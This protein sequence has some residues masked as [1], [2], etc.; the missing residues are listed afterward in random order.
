MNEAISTLTVM[1]KTSTEI[2]LYVSKVK[3]GLLE[4]YVTGLDAAQ[5]LKSME[6][7]VK[8]LKS[9]NDIRDMIL[10]DADKYTEKTIELNGCKFTK[11]TSSKYDYS[12]CGDSKFNKLDRQIKELTFERK[13]RENFLKALQEPQI[14]EETGEIINPA[15]STGSEVVA[16]TLAK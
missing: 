13:A 8:R 14:D 15:T 9:D 12:Q 2:N 7:I 1:P 4:G 5:L 6:E 3:E 11:R 16:V 10:E